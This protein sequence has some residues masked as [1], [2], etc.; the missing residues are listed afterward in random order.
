[1]SPEEYLVRSSRWLEIALLLLI[2]PMP[3]SGQTSAQKG[4][5]SLVATSGKASFTQKPDGVAARV[6]A[7]VASG[8]LKDLR[9]PDFSDYRLHLINFYRPSGYKP[10][11]IHDGEPT[12]QAIELI[13]I[14]QDADREGLLAEDYDASRWAD[15]LTL[16]KS[17]HE[18][19][20]EARFDAALT[21][22]IM[23]YV[24]D[25]H[26]GRI[27]PQNLD[28]AFDVSHKKL[29][30]PRFVRERLVNGSD[31]RSELAEIEPPFPSYQRLR[32]ALLH[33]MEL[34][35]KGDGEKV[36]DVGT[37]SP[38]GQYEG[39]TGL[40]NRL[41]L[42]GD[43]P[44]SVIIPADSKVYEGPLVDA[45]KHFQ[46]RCALRPTGVLDYKTVVEMNKPLSDRVEQMR[47]GLERYRWLPYQFKQPP[48][49]INVPEFRLYGLKE[50]NELGI[51]MRVN[52]GED[53]NYQTPMF[54]NNIQYIIFRPYWIPPPNILR[55]EIIPD[56]EKHPSLEKSGLELVS[57]NGQVIR[58]GNVTPAMLQQVRAGK[59]TVRQPPGPE[60][61]MGLVKFMFPNE[62][63][64][65]IHDTPASFDMF[66][67]EAEGAD[68][69]VKR[70]GS[71]GCIHAQEPAKLATWL[72]RNTPGWNLERVEHAMHEGRD[73][74]RVNVSPT[75]PVLIF[76]ETVVVEENGDVHFFH[77]IYDHD[78]TLRQELA[79]GY[80]YPK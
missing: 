16:L 19:I 61:G 12:T 80:P 32:A 73:N 9:W 39:I 45:V 58:S 25:V 29:D 67:E 54:E 57:A 6:S 44:D 46:G 75:I 5:S 15:R 27:N 68:G 14:L 8:H 52:V 74:V 72:L 79:E 20:D 56:F 35:K 1:M 51:T 36:L 59:L 70:V 18:D 30:L 31:L 21:V 69:E 64:V 3:I 50:G 60:N 23:R 17:P 13:Q 40:A 42:L 34:E 2:S 48:I 53:Y 65:Y 76:Y 41:R 43:L 62:Y 71:H 55:K 11:W 63:H 78:R 47:L 33:Y 37:V 49:V 4:T 22:C 24:S 26:I 10:A 66:S 7:I 28:F 38:G 77:D